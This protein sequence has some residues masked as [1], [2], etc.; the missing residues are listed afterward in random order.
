MQLARRRP[1]VLRIETDNVER[2][3]AD[4]DRGGDAELRHQVQQRE[5]KGRAIPPAPFAEPDGEGRSEQHTSELQ[6][7]MR[8]S[9][10]VFCLKKTLTHHR[11]HQPPGTS[12]TNHHT[13]RDN[14]T[15][16][17]NITPDPTIT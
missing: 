6:S 15:N 7:L 5:E 13:Q 2:R 11:H 12:H 17:N 9:Y 16:T 8:I 4:R 1:T 14:L 3:V 10:A